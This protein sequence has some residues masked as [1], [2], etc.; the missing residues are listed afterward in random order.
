MAG[1]VAAHLNTPPPQPSTT[2]PEVPEL[3][4]KVI[5]TG[6]AKDPDQRYATTVELASAAHDVITTP[7]PRPMRTAPASV[8]DPAPPTPAAEPAAQQQPADLNLAAT[9]QRPP[10]RPPVPQ[11]RPAERPGARPGQQPPPQQ[12]EGPS[13]GQ[14][15]SRGDRNQWLALGV[16]AL[17]VVAA[18][19]GAGI[20]FGTKKSNN[21]AATGTTATTPTPTANT[22]TP[23][24]TG[25]TT[26]PAAADVPGLAPFVGTWRAHV[27][28]TV[29]RSTGSG[30]LAY[31]DLAA[32]PSCAAANA[33]TGTVDFTL[34]SVS[35]DVATGEVTAS[36]DENQVVVGSPV[37]ATLGAG[38]PSGQILQMSVGRIQLPFCNNTSAGQCGA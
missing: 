4:D 24:P 12:P 9:Q 35:N 19:G 16:A 14:P 22:T 36:S 21:T 34:T 17:V 20:Y 6:M 25:T 8:A 28:I 2:Q 13:P 31:E 1:L 38:S 29:I 10:G 11:P 26:T 37:T 7:I 23:T 27:G 15:A 18:M 32:C 33:P 5:A 3:F 30:H